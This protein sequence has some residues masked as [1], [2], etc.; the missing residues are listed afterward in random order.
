[1]ASPPFAHRILLD[2]G[3]QGTVY[4]L[5]LAGQEN[6]SSAFTLYSSLFLIRI[7]TADLI[8][9]LSFKR[10]IY[11]IS[12]MSREGTHFPATT[13]GRLHATETSVVD[14]QRIPV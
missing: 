13:A 8:F 5:W 9:G 10:A 6:R 7:F 11:N 14:R 1:M 12:S 4:A 2:D 3:E